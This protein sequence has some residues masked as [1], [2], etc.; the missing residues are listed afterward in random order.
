MEHGQRNIE[1]FLHSKVSPLDG[2]NVESKP[3]SSKRSRSS[4]LAKFELEGDVDVIEIKSEDEGEDDVQEGDGSKVADYSAA[5]RSTDEDDKSSFR[6]AQAPC[7][8]CHRCHRLFNL[9][10][11]ADSNDNEDAYRE[12]LDEVERAQRA[13][14]ED[15]HFALDLSKAEENGAGNPAAAPAQGHI[16]RDDSLDRRVVKRTKNNNN[17]SNKGRKKE[18]EIGGIRS[19]FSPKPKA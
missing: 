13:E 7:W 15:Y 5:P 18:V 3:S 10:M 12:S 1:G 4:S 16:G 14:H 17:S 6:D 11:Y 8:T 19:F 9:P 2:L